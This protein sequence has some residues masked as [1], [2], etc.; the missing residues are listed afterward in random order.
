MISLLTNQIKNDI[1]HKNYADLEQKFPII[2]E[3]K[4]ILYF[5]LV[6]GN[7]SI[8]ISDET[9]YCLRNIWKGNLEET[10]DTAFKFRDNVLVKYTNHVEYSIQ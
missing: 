5:K 4:T 9:I 3:F 2:M 7:I 10:F 1:Y 8:A 6:N